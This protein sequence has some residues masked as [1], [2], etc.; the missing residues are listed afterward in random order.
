MQI[1]LT[2]KSAILA[3]IIVFSFVI[4]WELYLR[5]RGYPADYDDGPELWSHNRAM[6][7]EPADKATVFIGSS[8][9]K[10]D[11][12]IPTWEKSTGTHAIQLAMVGSSPRL[13]LTNLAEDPR[14]KGRL[15]IDVTEGL[16]F[17]NHGDIKPMAGITYF[18]QSTPAQK[19][20]FQLGLPM[21][22]KCVFLNSS[23]FSID[24]L[25]GRMHVPDRAG[26]MPFLDFPFGFEFNY[27][28]RQNKMTEDFVADTNQQNQ[29][30]AIWGMFAQRYGKEQPLCGMALDTLLQSVKTDID[31][32]LARGGRVIFTRTPSSGPYAMGEKMGY[33][34]PAYWDKLLDITGCKGIH[35]ADYPVTMHLECLEWSH[36]DPHDAVVY[37]NALV[38]ILK[39]EKGWKF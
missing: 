39:K 11:L 31:K 8:R 12:D 21:E 13:I 18:K 16:F 37:S 14:F 34:R 4:S 29:V 26:V 22:G 36:L 5:H 23:H 19:L 15:I 25:L 3:V 6:V 9:I 7:Y 17:G 28:D 20:S 2:A 32:I 33:P 1:Q 24:G 35:F 38:D 27:F 10:Y 30:K